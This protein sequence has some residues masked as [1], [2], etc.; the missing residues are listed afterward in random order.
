MMSVQYITLCVPTP[1]ADVGLGVAI[2]LVK[3]I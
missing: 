1:L 3:V 2:L